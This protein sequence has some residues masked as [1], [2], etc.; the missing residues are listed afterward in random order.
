MTYKGLLRR[1]AVPVAMAAAVTGG[2]VAVA[3]TAGAASG[4][5]P[6]A[7]V[8]IFQNANFGGIW[9]GQTDPYR[10]NVG[11]LMND[12][13]SSIVNW[14]NRDICFYQNADYGGEMLT[15]VPAGKATEWVGDNNN[16]RI[17]SFKPC[18]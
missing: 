7:M 16:D 14:T 11:D 12:R 8:C 13:T 18:W 2:T 5:C 6:A 15:W 9:I 4:D 1:V 3:P 10:P 17:S